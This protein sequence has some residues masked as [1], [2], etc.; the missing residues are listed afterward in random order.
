METPLT[1]QS[2]RITGEVHHVR[3]EN[4]DSGFAVLVMLDSSGRKFVACGVL[5]GSAPGK[6]LE[7]TGHFEDHAEFGREFKADSVRVIRY[8]AA[9]SFLDDLLGLRSALTPISARIARLLGTDTSAGRLQAR[10][11]P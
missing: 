7:L 9:S 2:V 3:Y 8:Q 6:T 10:Y 1:P 11:A 5:A 4:P